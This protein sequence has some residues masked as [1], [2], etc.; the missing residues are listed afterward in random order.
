MS[1]VITTFTAE[2]TRPPTAA[3]RRHGRQ[4]ARVCCSGPSRRP[5][6]RE[7]A[8]RARGLC[9]RSPGDSA[10]VRDGRRV[11]PQAAAQTEG[12]STRASIPSP[13]CARREAASI[14]PDPA[15]RDRH[16]RPLRRTSS[17]ARDALARDAVAHLR[18]AA[19][20]GCA[21]PSPPGGEVEE[22]AVARPNAMSSSEY[23]P[24]RGPRPCRS[25]AAWGVGSR[26]ALTDG[27]CRERGSGLVEGPPRGCPP[28]CERREP[29]DAALWPPDRS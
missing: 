27:V 25:I 24:R 20:A 5:A 21:R 3:V 17:A 7:P 4:V 2:P 19:C 11:D 6:R 14:P 26:R 29:L 23:E 8:G 16:Q 1:R 9:H 28:G 18:A 22:R 10:E 12:R 15:R 13:S